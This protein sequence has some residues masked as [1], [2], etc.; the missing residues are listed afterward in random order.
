MW[1]VLA[2]IASLL[3]CSGCEPSVAPTPPKSKSLKAAEPVVQA[4]LLA[5]RVGSEEAKAAAE[6]AAKEVERT[7]NPKTIRIKAQ[8]GVSGKGEYDAWIATTPLW[9]NFSLKEQMIFEFQI[10]KAVQLFESLRNRKPASHQEFMHEIIMKS[11][12]R[13]PTL[14]PDH[15]Y[16]Y[17]PQTG[18]LMVEKPAAAE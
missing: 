14:P 18:E 9:A 2:V 16:I 10:P 12:I 7:A 3:L 11:N 8:P 4:P 17:D 13:L 15:R 1:R 5:P 6:V